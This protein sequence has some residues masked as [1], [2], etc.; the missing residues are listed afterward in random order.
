MPTF[1][2]MTKLASGAMES[3]D[4]RLRQGRKWLEKVEK[5]CPDVKWVGHYAIF[6]PYDFMDI[7]EATSV[8]SAQKVSLISRAEGATTA[9][10]WQAVPY[11][12]FVK[13]LEKLD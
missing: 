5:A 10:S 4:K 13:L 3:A 9:E 6:G 12:E 11:D 1:V 2:L 8:E 7:F